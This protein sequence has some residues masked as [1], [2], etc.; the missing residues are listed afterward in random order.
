MIFIRKKLSE[1]NQKLYCR[2]AFLHFS[3]TFLISF[4]SHFSFDSNLL[5]IHNIEALRG[6][7]NTL[8]CQVIVLTI[9]LEL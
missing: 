7:S 3:F 2:R 9:N 5:T 8:T 6:L 4:I 1:I